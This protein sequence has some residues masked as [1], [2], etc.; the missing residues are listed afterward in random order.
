LQALAQQ[1]QLRAQIELGNYLYVNENY[2]E[3]FTWYQ[4]AAE[5]GDA[6]A[7]SALA[8]MYAYG[9]GVPQNLPEAFRWAKNAADRGNAQA[10]QLLEG[11]LQQSGTSP[12][13]PAQAEE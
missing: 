8:Y 7:Q 1:G 11:V 10:R 9:L 12:P 13:S 4:R 5:Q 3:A 2:A 6:G